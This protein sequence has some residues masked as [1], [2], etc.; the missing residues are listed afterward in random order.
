MSD[1]PK[2]GNN[3][4]RW[5]KGTSG[6]RSGRPAGSRNKSTVVLEQMLEGERERIMRKLID[7][8]LD[9]DVTAIRLCM[10]RLLPPRKDRPVQLDLPP[11]QT[12]EQVSIAMGRVFQAIAEG[13]ITPGEGETLVK[14]LAVQKEVIATAELEP[15]M[16]KLEEK[17]IAEQLVEQVHNGQ[18]AEIAQ[19]NVG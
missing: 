7:L 14:L 12:M 18:L 19:G 4:G 13:Q 11:I 9:S 1:T 8:A 2:K 5:A 3:D 17:K 16:E 6:N 10:D 15:R